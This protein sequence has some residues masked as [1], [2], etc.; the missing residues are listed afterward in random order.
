MQHGLRFAFTLE[1]VPQAVLLGGQLPDHAVE[2]AQPFLQGGALG[3][4]PLLGL[5]ECRPGGHYV[6]SEFDFELLEFADLVGEQ[7]RF[8]SG[9]G[10]FGLCRFEI[11][12]GFVVGAPHY[13]GAGGE[14][15]ETQHHGCCGVDLHAS[16]RWLVFHAIAQRAAS[17]LTLTSRCRRRIPLSPREITRPF[18]EVLSYGFWVLSC[19][20]QY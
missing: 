19:L 20:A 18:G 2:C 5:L 7:L 6:R 11:V 4:H 1:G 17:S 14:C 15:G 13:T 3:F 12:D 16:S 9:A 10:E 8:G